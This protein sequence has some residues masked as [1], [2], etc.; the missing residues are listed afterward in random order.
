MLC[1]REKL[2]TFNSVFQYAK[3]NTLYDQAIQ[4]NT[5]VHIG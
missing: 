4:S 2:G 5:V 3:Y 1:Q